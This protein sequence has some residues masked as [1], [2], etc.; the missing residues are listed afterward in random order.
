MTPPSSTA[1]RHQGGPPARYGARRPWTRPAAVALIVVLAVVGAAWLTWAGLHHSSPAV[2]ARVETFEV[3]S[4]SEVSVTV[5]IERDADTAVACLLIAHAQDHAVVGER[6]V[7]VPAGS[8]TTFTRTYTVTT[9]RAA[10]AGALDGCRP[11]DS[12][13]TP[14]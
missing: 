8:Q 1:S 13:A 10:T 12:G 3:T 14:P 2:S 5:F 9:E 7:V 6:E 4:P 11:V